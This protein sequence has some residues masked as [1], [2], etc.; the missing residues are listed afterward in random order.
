M[1]SFCEFS[2]AEFTHL[3]SS[4]KKPKITASWKLPLQLLSK[5]FL[6]FLSGVTLSWLPEAKPCVCAFI[7]I[8]AQSCWSLPLVLF[9]I[10][11]PAPVQAQYLSYFWV[12]FSYVWLFMLLETFSCVSFS[13]YTGMILWGLCVRVESVVRRCVH[14]QF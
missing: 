7:H 8:A 3:L 10:L 12:T 9:C 11:L 5:S 1:I 6:P 4:L 14:V 13:K 2:Q